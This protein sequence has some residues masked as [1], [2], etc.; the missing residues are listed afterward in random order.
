MA[1]NP[2]NGGLAKIQSFYQTQNMRMPVACMVSV[3]SGL[4]PPNPLGSI[5]IF[6]GVQ[7]L[8]RLLSDAVSTHSEN[9]VVHVYV[10][11]AKYM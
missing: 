4:F 10:Q 1:N 7:N 8:F 6:G 11:Y 2:C 5:S 9:V 3:G